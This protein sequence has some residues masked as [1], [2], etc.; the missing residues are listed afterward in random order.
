MRRW[1]GWEPK[2]TTTV[3]ERDEQGRPSKWV[4]EVEPEYDANE[5]D[6]WQALKEYEDALCPQC[7]GLRSECED[8][9]KVW[10]PDIHT[11]YRTSARTMYDR[12]WKKQWEKVEPDA[13]F[14]HPTD[15]GFLHVSQ[16]EPEIPLF[17]SALDADE[18][19]E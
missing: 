14:W 17:S 15:G 3:L 9:T 5:R 12:R 10:H 18:A 1:L 8:P 4:E 6:N 7:G 16:T 13:D 19:V 11:C 2:R